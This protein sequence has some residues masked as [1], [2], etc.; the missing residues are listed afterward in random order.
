MQVSHKVSNKEIK[1]CANAAIKV[2]LIVG[3]TLSLINQFQVVTN[4][5]TNTNEVIKIVMNFI[6]PFC[7]AMYSRYMLLLELKS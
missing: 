6:V 1:M 5:F 7:V 3:T 4:G 2:A